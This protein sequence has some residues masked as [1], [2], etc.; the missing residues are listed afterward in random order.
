MSSRRFAGRSGRVRARCRRAWTAA[1][2]VVAWGGGAAGDDPVAVVGHYPI[3]LEDVE[4]AAERLGGSAVDLAALSPERR[5]TALDALIAARLLALEAER[6]GL[7][8]A[9]AVTAVLDSLEGALLAE[10]IRE[11]D[12]GRTRTAAPAD[13]AVRALYAAWGSGIEVHAAHILVGSRQEAEEVLRLLG[14][15]ADF[16]ELARQRSQHTMSAAGGGSMGFMR[17]GQF[18]EAIGAAVWN[19]GP[20]SV[21][22][23]PIRTSLGWHVVR[24]V[25]RRLVSLEDQR[26]ALVAQLERL[27]KAR[28]DSLF[29]ESLRREYGLVYHPE[30]AARV[31]GLQDTLAGDRLL[32]HWRGGQLDLAGFLARAQVPDPVSQDTA[33]M[34]GLAEAIAFHDLAVAAA[35]ERG[36]GQL[37]EVRKRLEE[38]RLQLLGERLFEAETSPVPGRAEMQAFYEARQ[39]RYRDPAVVTV[40]EILVDEEA[41]ADSLYR[42]IRDPGADMADLARRH[43]VRT[44]LAQT[45]GLWEQVEPADPRSAKIYRKAVECGPGL[46]PP[47]KVPGGFSVFEVLETRPGRPLNFDEVEDA[48][49][50]DMATV[51]MDRLIGELRQRFGDRIEVRAGALNA[52]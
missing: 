45:G 41:V 16:G 13:S 27:E 50:A 2:A 47:L 10:A 37:S 22:P 19:V 36:Y 5:Q 24:V 20:E 35:R 25:D 29:R 43:T 14:E 21:Y 34:R 7:D 30:T 44:D 28:A 48:V 1:F 23:E 26:P 38:K 49:R 15:G 4:R 31:A 42:L 46:Q 33:R 39:D 17:R 52:R 8:R 9:S 51:A 12:A 18:L 6:R 32:F 40:R 3:H 11:R